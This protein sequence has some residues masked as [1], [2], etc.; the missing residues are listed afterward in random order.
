MIGAAC[1][2]IRVATG[3]GKVREIQGQGNSGNFE[4]GQGNLGKS[5]E[6]QG[7]LPFLSCAHKIKWSHDAT[8]WK[9]YVYNN[10]TKIEMQ[11]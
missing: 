5:L 4:K 11:C 2:D 8:N 3:Q 10:T 9:T 6:S 1:A 7:I